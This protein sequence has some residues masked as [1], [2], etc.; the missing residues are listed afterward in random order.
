MDQP[1]V[2]QTLAAPVVTIQ[3]KP[4]PADIGIPTYDICQL[5]LST[6][7]TGPVLKVG[8][9][10]LPATK[11]DLG[12]AQ[13]AYAATRG[14]PAKT[15]AVGQGGY[16]TSRFAVFLLSG[17]LYKVEGPAAAPAKYVAL[18]QEAARQAPGVPESAPLIT[19][20][21][22]E[23]G[24]GQGDGCRGDGPSGRRDGRG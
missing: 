23:R 7:P 20:P 17:R 6:S 13:K 9:S 8:T 22:C 4:V 15:I 21:D 16:G 11:A 14:E 12:A 5:A 18:A 10:V 24:G 2:Q 19:R 3:E 1:L